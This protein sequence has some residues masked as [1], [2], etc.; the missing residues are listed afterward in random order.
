MV[1]LTAFKQHAN[2]QVREELNILTQKGFPRMYINQQPTRIEELLEM[3][4]EQL[5][6]TILSTAK[7]LCFN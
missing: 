1:I 5:N 2:R 6:A 3:N 7:G 4:D